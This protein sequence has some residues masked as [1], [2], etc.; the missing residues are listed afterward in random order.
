MVT[1]VK[2]INMKDVVYTAA[3]SWEKI[4][5]LT[6]SKSWLKLLG[7]V[8]STE[9]DPPEQETSD[10]PSCEELAQMLDADLTETDIQEWTEA[11]SNDHGHQLYTDEEIISQV[12]GSEELCSEEEDEG[13]K[14]HFSVSL[15]VRQQTCLNN[16]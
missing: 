8:H 7:E 13:G 12:T 3:A 16:A 10:D 1:Y 5:P 4:T 11:D 9:S 14:G 6:L 15:V 2:T